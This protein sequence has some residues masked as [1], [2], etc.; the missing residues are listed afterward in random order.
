M[1]KTFHINAPAR[2]GNNALLDYRNRKKELEQRLDT[3]NKYID[4]LEKLKFE[5]GQVAIHKSEGAVIIRDYL[6]KDFQN[7]HEAPNPLVDNL[8]EDCEVGYV[9]VGKG[10]LMAATDEDLVEYNDKSKILYDK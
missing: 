7:I 8:P 4:L 2:E 9:V 6:V 10:D 1:A 5:P 3:V